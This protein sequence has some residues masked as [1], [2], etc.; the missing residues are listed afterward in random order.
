MGRDSCFLQRSTSFSH[1]R[2]DAFQIFCCVVLLGLIFIS[3]A[4]VLPAVAVDRVAML[5]AVRTATVIGTVSIGVA[6]SGALRLRGLL[7]VALALSRG[8]RRRCGR[9]LARVHAHALLS[10]PLV[11]FRARRAVA[12][13]PRALNVG[14]GRERASARVE[15]RSR[16]RGA[17]ARTP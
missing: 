4:V 14:R 2:G 7:D 13:H 17:S 12:A 8:P 5:T 9:G 15:T 1:E 10:T 6:R 3:H 11:T 16:A